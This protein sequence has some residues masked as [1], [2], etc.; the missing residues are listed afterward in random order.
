M[1]L[2]TVQAV[3]HCYGSCSSPPV[4][5]VADWSCVDW[6][7]VMPSNVT[8]TA[9]QFLSV[10][11]HGLLHTTLQPPRPATGVPLC[12]CVA[13]QMEH[14]SPRPLATC[15]CHVARKGLEQHGTSRLFAQR[16]TGFVQHGKHGNIAEMVRHSQRR[17]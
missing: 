13:I 12:I 2:F 11:E 8:C 3:I 15:S 16:A 6:L 4:L 9:W 1:F 7:E 17:L 14:N 5:D 10:A